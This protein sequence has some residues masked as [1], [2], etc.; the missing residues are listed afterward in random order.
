MDGT[1]LKEVERDLDKAIRLN[2]T[3]GADATQQQLADA[4]MEA[5]STI[6]RALGRQNPAQEDALRRLD[7]S[8]AMLSRIRDAA[9]RRADSESRF[10]PVDMLQATKAGERRF[11]DHWS[12]AKGNAM[13]QAFAEE[14]NRVIGKTGSGATQPHGILHETARLL[15][16]VLGAVPYAA[17]RALPGAGGGI[18]QASPYLSPVAGAIAGEVPRSATTDSY[19]RGRGYQLP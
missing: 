4:L 13:M 17:S 9:T 3:S 12:F 15:G 16:G 5:R 14:A 2:R 11:G 8:W 7:T 19:Y 18:Q 1:T 10:T 6:F